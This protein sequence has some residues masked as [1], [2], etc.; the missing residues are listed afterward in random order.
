MTT[1]EAAK[2]KQVIKLRDT[3]KGSELYIMAKANLI[4]KGE[5]F[6]TLAGVKTQITF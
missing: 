3:K 6:C 1:I 4:H 2:P 5:Y